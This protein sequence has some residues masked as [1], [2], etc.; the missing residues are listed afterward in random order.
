MLHVHH[1][2]T[3]IIN[4]M[5]SL[6]HL[7]TQPPQPGCPPASMSVANAGCHNTVP[8]LPLSM[9]IPVLPHVQA[10][11][12]LLQHTVFVILGNVLLHPA[13]A[14]RS[15]LVF[16]LCHSRNAAMHFAEGRLPITC[17]AAVVFCRQ[18]IPTVCSADHCVLLI[19]CSANCVFCRQLCSANCV[20]CQQF[21]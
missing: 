2:G 8:S 14:A 13:I 17:C 1:C 21:H 5:L 10:T 20:F 16:M 12:L 4:L 7:S 15:L 3:A 11:R 19:V 6:R 9:V 18:C